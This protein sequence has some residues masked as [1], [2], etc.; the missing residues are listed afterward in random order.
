MPPLPALGLALPLCSVGFIPRAAG[1][2]ARGS[3]AGPQV[4]VRC[5]WAP[6]QSQRRERNLEQR[7]SR[8]LL[9]VS[10]PEGRKG[11][12]LP[13]PQ[14][15]LSVAEAEAGTYVPHSC[16]REAQLR[17]CGGLTLPSL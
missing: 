11:Q 7:G 9:E 15:P 1:K 17:F 12:C 8:K 2:G 16:P 14:S 6:L 5:G 3:A 10:R 4:A 13:L